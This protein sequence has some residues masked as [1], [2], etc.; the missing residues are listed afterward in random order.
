MKHWIDITTTDGAV[1]KSTA[2]E[3]RAVDVAAAMQQ[4]IDEGHGA[5]RIETGDDAWV[6]LRPEDIA[7]V[8]VNGISEEVDR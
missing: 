1:V 8:A 3:G 7:R 2:K 6:V 4:T 5:L